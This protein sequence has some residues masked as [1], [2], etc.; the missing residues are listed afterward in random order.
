MLEKL[1]L[2]PHCLLSTWGHACSG[3]GP[4][5]EAGLGRWREEDLGRHLEA[6]DVLHHQLHA[7]RR[8]F[9]DDG[10][11]GEVGADFANNLPPGAVCSIHELHEL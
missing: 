11:D 1:R 10:G 5:S 2:D 6:A 7:T 4:W 3:T 8:D 9:A